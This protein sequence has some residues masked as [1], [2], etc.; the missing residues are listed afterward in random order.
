MIQ[1]EKMGVLHPNAC[2]RHG[3]EQSPR[4]GKSEVLFLRKFI[5][6]F[7]SMTLLLGV[8]L[9]S[10]LAAGK[11]TVTLSSGQAQA[12]ERVELE[13]SIRDNPGLAAFML[14]LSFDTSVFSLSVDEDVEGAGKFGSSGSVVCSEQSDGLTVLWF[15]G[16]GRNVAA[17]GAMLTV[18]L[19]VAATAKPGAYPVRLDYD[20]EN[21]ANGDEEPVALSTV[22]GTVTVTGGATTGGSVV[23]PEPEP[24]PDEPVF[25]DIGGHW[26]EAEILKSAE[27]GLINGFED[28]TYRPNETMTRAQCVTI[29]WRASGRPEPKG[30][31]T[32]TDLDPRQEWYWKAVAWAAENGVV[33][34]V[35]NGKFD[36]NGTVTREQLVTI[37]H[38]MAGTPLGMEQMFTSQYDAAHPDSANVQSWAKQAVYWAIYKDICCGVDSTDLKQGDELKPAAYATRAQI[39]VMMVRYLDKYE[40]GAEE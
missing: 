5:A 39:A 22:S 1:C 33:N 13:V 36:P 8:S 40:G 21:T 29:L 35:G 37:L 30:E 20:F 17:D 11:P 3:A 4:R 25:P 24:E 9:P 26:A 14:Y 23:Q 6:V 27:L 16:S 28:G 31:A 10:A 7:L 2:R 12:G 38:R 15:N 19:S 34:G 32:F 18:T